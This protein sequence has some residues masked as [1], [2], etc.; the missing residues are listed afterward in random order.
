MK[1]QDYIFKKVPS[2]AI[3]LGWTMRFVLCA[4]LIIIE[5]TTVCRPFKL[6]HT[7]LYTECCRF[8]L[9]SGV[10]RR[11]HISHELGRS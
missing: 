5:V 1:S 11:V 2:G 9:A 8:L 10:K 4:A 3:S 6:R 7:S